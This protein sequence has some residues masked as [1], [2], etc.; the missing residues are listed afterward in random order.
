MFVYDI[1]VYEF[2]SKSRSI[3]IKHDFSMSCGFFIAVINN[4][5]MNEF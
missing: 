2:K 5:A 3:W 4:I 1:L